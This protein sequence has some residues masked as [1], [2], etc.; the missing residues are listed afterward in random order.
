VASKATKDQKVVDEL[1]KQWKDDSTYLA[2]INLGLGTSKPKNKAVMT[3]GVAPS[4][5]RLVNDVAET[6]LSSGKQPSKTAVAKF[7][8]MGVD[9]VRDAIESHKILVK[10]GAGGSEETLE[11]VNWLEDEP[12][13]EIGM[14]S[15]NKRLKPYA[16]VVISD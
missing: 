15:F 10:Y 8:G 1:V 11:L 3:I 6:F 5:C 4:W 9:W 16:P 14:S 2:I 12:S 13:V 7:F